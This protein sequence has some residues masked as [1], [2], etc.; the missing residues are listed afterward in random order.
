MKAL[1]KKTDHELIHLFTDGNLDAL[2]TL[3]LR[4]KDKLYTSILFLVKDKYLA[5]TLQKNLRQLHELEDR[6]KLQ[7]VPQHLDYVPSDE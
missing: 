5:E 1:V 2:E 4:H 7:A 3:I 6:G